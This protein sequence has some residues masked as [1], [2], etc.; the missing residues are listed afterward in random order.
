M[1]VKVICVPP[2]TEGNDLVSRSTVQTK[3]V[4]IRER[5]PEA[6]PADGTPVGVK[7][8]SD[9]FRREGFKNGPRLSTQISVRVG[10]ELAQLSR[11]GKIK[12][13]GRGL[14]ARIK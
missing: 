11:A 12:R 8:V 2:G 3:S 1:G 14:Y 4:R 7:H 10:I 6:L 5:I 13:V 9:W